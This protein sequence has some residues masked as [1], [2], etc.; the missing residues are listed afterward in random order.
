MGYG[1]LSI[2]SCEIGRELVDCVMQLLAAPF[3]QKYGAGA[4]GSTINID[5]GNNNFCNYCIFLI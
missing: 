3:I 1:N 5:K 2:S 4:S